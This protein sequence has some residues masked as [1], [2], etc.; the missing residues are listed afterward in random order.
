MK[1][2]TLKLEDEIALLSKYRI[3]P[4]EL[5]FVR[6]LLMLQDE[7]NE[8]IFQSYIE[9][10]YESGVK[11]REVIL[12]LQDKGVILKTFHCPKEGEAFDSLFNID[13]EKINS[14]DRMSRNYSDL[15]NV[16]ASR[17]EELTRRKET[18]S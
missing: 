6:T 16:I 10:L 18:N 11:T 4:N 9:A 3:T 15:E 12:N 7:E 13:R 5:M 2:L 8:D 17:Y 14:I 1:N